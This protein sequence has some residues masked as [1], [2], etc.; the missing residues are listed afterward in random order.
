MK[1]TTVSYLCG[2]GLS[3]MS[4]ALARAQEADAT[5]PVLR[6]GPATHLHLS[7]AL[8]A[9]KVGTPRYQTAIALDALVLRIPTPDAP[10]P[11]AYG[12]NLRGAFTTLAS[13]LFELQGVA[14]VAPRISDNVR[15]LGLATAGYS[16]GWSSHYPIFDDTKTPANVGGF[17]GGTRQGLEWNVG[18]GVALATAV[19]AEYLAL[20]TGEGSY[21]PGGFLGPGPDPSRTESYTRERDGVRIMLMLGIARI[22]STASVH[23]TATP[24]PR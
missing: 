12:G 10:L 9:E 6:S 15:Y 4:P 7:A 16:L 19:A 8:G 23:A 20:T 18:G 17:V 24:N 2:I 22:G 21:I 1:H 11:L 3:L 5:E 14:G 13:G